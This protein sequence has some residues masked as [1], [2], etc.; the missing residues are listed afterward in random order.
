MKIKKTTIWQLISAVLAV[1]LAISIYTGG[2]K[3]ESGTIES[4][5][6]LKGF[7]AVLINDKRCVEC[8][9][10][11]LV[12]QLKAVFPTLEIK[13]LDYSSKEG[14][15]LY[16]ETKL[17]ALPAL[18]FTEEV[19]NSQNYT[20]VERYI[21][22]AGKY[23]SLRVGASF[24]P[25][26]EI[27]DNKIDDDKDSKID[28]EDDSC[29]GSMLCREETKKKLDVFVMSQCPY[30]TKALDAMKE[31]LENFK[32]DIDFDI[33]YIANENAD[34]TFASLHGQAEVDEDIRELCAV[35]NYPDDYKYMDYIWCRNKKI[36][37]TAWEGCAEE[38]FGASDKIKACFEGAEGK[39]LLSE[40]IKN[41]N[42]LKIGA[43]PTWLANNRYK[44]SGIDAETV[45]KSFCQYNTGLSGCSNTLTGDAA[46]VPAGG[47]GA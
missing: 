16:E 25:A 9:T 31:V 18:L 17:T 2:F 19:K 23:L 7:S 38:A 36:T 37:D 35:K 32:S 34:G 42:S 44:F 27:C 4:K 13:E 5:T 24:D 21:D 6:D 1:L 39:K 22:P 40:N 3:K 26:A 11:M 46:A 28:C 15:A 14:K 20:Q 33:Y 43:S 10:T 47:C 8:D 41:A 12:S 29:E 30:G 45:K